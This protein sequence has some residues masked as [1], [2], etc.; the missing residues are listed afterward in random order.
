MCSGFQF[1]KYFGDHFLVVEMQFLVAD[2]EIVFVSLAGY[3]YYSALGGEH[4]GRADGF[5]A[6]GDEYRLGAGLGVHSGFDVIHYVQR[7]L[8]AGIVA[9]DNDPVG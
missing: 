1:V 4:Y 2:D 9:G 6:V 3:E 5:L 7:I 8:V